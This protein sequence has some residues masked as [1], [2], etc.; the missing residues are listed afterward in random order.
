[1]KVVG[2]VG[3]LRKNSRHMAMMK[4][5]QSVFPAGAE[6]TIADLNVPLFNEDLEAD[7]PESVKILQDQVNGA[8]AV[9]VACPEYNY[10]VT[11]ALKNALD[12]V[13]RDKRKP[14]AKKPTAIMSFGGMSGGFSAQNVFRQSL[15]FLDATGVG[16]PLCCLR[17]SP[18]PF[19]E[20]DGLTVLTDE[21]SKEK[22]KGIVDALVAL[23]ESSK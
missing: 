16:Q 3:S 1:M 11:A 22:V 2:L 9:L 12:W 5:A 23:S 10:G 19:E 17:F 21:V 14:W 6:V 20:V 15:L 7:V 13:S 8:D 18:M 4:Y